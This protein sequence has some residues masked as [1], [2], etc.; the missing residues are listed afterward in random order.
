MAECVM[1]YFRSREQQWYRE[2][3]GAVPPP[4][5]NIELRT[6]RQNM[7]EVMY[8]WAEEYF[9]P[10]GTKLNERLCKQDVYN[11]FLSIAGDPRYHGVT[12]SG[13]TRKLQYYCRFKGYDFNPTKNNEAG[14]C[15]ADWKPAHPSES[16]IGEPDKSNGKIY[17]TVHCPDA[18]HP[19]PF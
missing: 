3:K 7:S 2:G 4:M 10:S 11:D 1:Y 19:K 14:M 15:Y 17:I 8:Q 16:F 5:R 12:P 18:E 6:L 9:D 13:F